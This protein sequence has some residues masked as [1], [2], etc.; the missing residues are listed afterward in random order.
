MP[1]EDV[2]RRIA[3]LKANSDALAAE[4]ASLDRKAEQ[5]TERIRR[6]LVPKAVSSLILDLANR[7]LDRLRDQA[8][9][10]DFTAH[11]RFLRA[12]CASVPLK[13]FDPGVDSGT[14]SLLGLCAELWPQIGNRELLSHFAGKQSDDPDPQGV[15]AGM[16]SILDAFQ[17]PLMSSDDADERIRRLF[18]RFSSPVIEPAL[19]ISV[20]ETITGFTVIREMIADRLSAAEDLAR[21]MVEQWLQFR[22]MSATGM[23][24]TVLRRRLPQRAEMEPIAWSFHEGVEARTRFLVFTSADLDSAINCKGQPF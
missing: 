13:Q 23:S 8:G 22:E 17:A 10:S 20:S 1:T 16:M 6:R 7:E 24:E 5:L 18:E 15:A 3:K 19:S 2:M 4:I 14:D 9:H 11:A 21:P 12:L